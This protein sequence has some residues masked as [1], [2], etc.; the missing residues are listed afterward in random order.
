M[1]IIIAF[2]LATTCLFHGA[3]HRESSSPACWSATV[4]AIELSLE[5]LRGWLLCNCWGGEVP[6]EFFLR[7][8]AMRIEKDDVKHFT[9][10]DR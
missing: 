6:R 2:G 10:N 8:K 1:A 3:T 4:E 5:A 7:Y 9:P